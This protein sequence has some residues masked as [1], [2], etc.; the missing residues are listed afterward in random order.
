MAIRNEIISGR[1]WVK[2]DFLISEDLKDTIDEIVR[3]VEEG[4]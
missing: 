2:G 1:D 3:I 4:Y